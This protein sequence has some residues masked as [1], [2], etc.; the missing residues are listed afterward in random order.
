MLATD[1]K[2]IKDFIV[3]LYYNN[4][5]EINKY[6]SELINRERQKAILEFEETGFTDSKEEKYLYTNIGAAY[7]T[8]YK[9]LFNPVNAIINLEEIF[10]CDVP[11]LDTNVLVAVNGWFHGKH[12]T[13]K[14]FE[15]GMITGSLSEASKKYPAIFQKY[16]NKLSENEKDGIISQNTAF[17]QDGIFIYV[18]EGVVMEK[19]VQIINLAVSDEEVLMCQRNLVIAEKN[20]DVKIIICDHSLTYHNFLFNNLTEI[21]AEQNSRIDYY[22]VQNSHNHST[23]LSTTHISQKEKSNVLFDLITLHGG[24]VR[25]NIKILLEE[26]HCESFTGSL[27]LADKSQHVDNYI[28]VDHIKPD[29]T[30]R[31]IFRGVYD[32]NASGVFHGKILVRKDA[33][34]TNALQTNNNILLTDEAKVHS[35]P[36][37]EIYADDVK[38][39]HG[40][41]IGQLDEN[42]IFYMR[43]RGIELKEAKLL[44]MHSFSY[45]II[46]QLRILPLKERIDDLVNRRLRG[47][48]SR[49]NY[50]SFNC[51]KN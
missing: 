37:L 46:K 28:F 38:C 45:E 39:S 25:N 3:N 51:G 9:C 5:E 11:E 17:A 8:S 20:S 16:Y 12:Q 42:A 13:L 7:K 44:L 33:Q 6:S 30:S 21:F 31:Q 1:T 15:N 48:F 14:V 50:C 4:L 32:D 47:D 43:S 29:C 2:N 41:T 26:P 36:Q 10:R 23:Q 35:Q 18:P 40:A 49:C 27:C 22:N 19:P 34:H 24:L